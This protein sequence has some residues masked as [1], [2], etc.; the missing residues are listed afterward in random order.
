QQADAT[1]WMAM[2]SLNML[3]MS[4]ELARKNPSYEE[5]ASKFFRHF[6]NIAWAMHHIG[7]KDLSLWDE[8]D[9]FYYDVVQL[10]S[11]KNERLK[12]RSL[13][14]IIP[15]FA[16]E[17]LNENLFD[18]MPEFKKRAVNIMRSRPDLAELISHIDE[19]NE[20]GAHLFSILRTYRL[21]KV[22]KRL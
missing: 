7:E 8:E 2:F 14:G 5:S 3:R 4:L 18:E 20:E 12:V 13:V 1:S 15:L 17:I 21:E 11:G 19:K 10:D 22:L 16:V 9:D 6:L